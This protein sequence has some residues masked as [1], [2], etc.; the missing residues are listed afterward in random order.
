MMVCWRCTM[1][2]QSQ[3][4]QGAEHDE[5]P[6]CRGPGLGDEEDGDEEQDG[7]NYKLYAHAVCSL[8][9]SEGGGPAAG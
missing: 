5:R 8:Q 7:S 6:E 3:E 2:Y 9:A 1:S 4:N